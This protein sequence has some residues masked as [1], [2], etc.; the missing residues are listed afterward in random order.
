VI[1]VERGALTRLGMPG[2]AYPI[3]M[4]D[5]RRLVIRDPLSRVAIVSVDGATPPVV[6]ASSGL[7]DYP[8]ST[9][10]DGKT[11]A[12]IRLNSSTA[13]DVYLLPVD[14]GEAQG[15]IAG[16]AYEGAPQISPDGRWLAYSSDESGRMEIYLRPLGASDRRWTVSTNGGLHPLWS[17][18][19]KRIFY[20]SGQQMLVADVATDGDVRLS[21]P[22]VLFDRRYE[23]GPNISQAN[24]SMS[25][26][27]R[28]LLMVKPEG[29]GQTLNLILNRLAAR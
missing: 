20:R 15:L 21:P 17:R 3:W 23:F 24:Y 2:A 10:P 1:E 7:N 26:D 14:A 4:P 22:R 5:S 19:G 25:L 6:V 8:S 9:S 29:T 13:G 27:D 16:T 11:I 12:V 28:R 18:D